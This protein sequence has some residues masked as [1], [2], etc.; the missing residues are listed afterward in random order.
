MIFPW[1]VV[2][3]I[4]VNGVPRNMCI[5]DP[6]LEIG[7][8]CVY[9]NQC[10]SAFCSPYKK[11]CMVDSSTPV[12]SNVMKAKNP[13]AIY[14]ILSGDMC[15]PDGSWDEAT[16][17][18]CMC[19]EAD[20]GNPFEEWDQAACGCGDEYLKMY[21]A[22]TWV[23]CV[24]CT[25]KDGTGAIG[26]ECPYHGDAKCASCDAGFLFDG[27]TCKGKEATAKEQKEKERQLIL[28][29]CI[30]GSA[31]VV[32]GVVL[33]FLHKITTMRNTY[34]ERDIGGDEEIIELPP[35]PLKK[36][37]MNTNHI[38][39]LDSTRI[40]GE[41]QVEKEKDKP[42]V[43]LRN[44]NTR[45]D[46]DDNDPRDDND[47]NTRDDNDDNTRDSDVGSDVLF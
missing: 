17:N 4:V 29:F 25:C 1:I 21:Y 13:E 2:G 43:L 7:Q 39:P 31:F 26:S 14:R 37:K 5:P 36:K 19:N 20:N 42:R 23:A 28:Y 18:M 16:M 35:P 27:T 12:S 22:E 45:E 15:G 47:D 11:I 38:A 10:I 6:K 32:I 46:N 24:V 34:Q 8:A 44:D 3:M 33:L 9:S 30:T 41:K 40:T